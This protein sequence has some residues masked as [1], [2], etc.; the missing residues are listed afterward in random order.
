MSATGG[1]VTYQGQLRALRSRFEALSQDAH[2]AAQTHAV[3][4]DGASYQAGQRDAYQGAATLL[5]A[6]VDGHAMD[7]TAVD[8]GT[9]GPALARAITK[10]QF[11][12]EVA[13]S[14]V[15]AGEMAPTPMCMRL[16]VELARSVDRLQR[17]MRV[18]K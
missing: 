9:R 1:A 6:I 17:L 15:E 14:S 16:M 8:V 7:A 12:V 5:A 13:A 2:G 18:M 10:A 3:A 4:G 11:L